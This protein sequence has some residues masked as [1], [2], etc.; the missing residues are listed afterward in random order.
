MLNR[1]VPLAWMGCIALA[2]GAAAPDS[3]ASADPPDGF[4]SLFDGQTLDGWHGLVGNPIKRAAMD[5]ESL[6]AARRVSS[7]SSMK[8]SVAAESPAMPLTV[9]SPSDSGSMRNPGTWEPARWYKKP[10]PSGS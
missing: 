3:R 5:A 2:T 10:W 8:R 1:H 6:K 9:V 4:V 7:T